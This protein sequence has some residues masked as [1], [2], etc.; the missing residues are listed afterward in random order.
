MQADAAMARP[1][2]DSEIVQ[3]V[4]GCGVLTRLM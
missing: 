2:V 1:R 4:R 3:E